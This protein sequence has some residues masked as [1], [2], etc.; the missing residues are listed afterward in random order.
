MEP[1]HKI[2][3]DVH[4]HVAYDFTACRVTLTV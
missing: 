4:G 3:Y 1:T 2:S